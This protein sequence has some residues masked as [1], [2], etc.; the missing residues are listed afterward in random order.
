MKHTKKNTNVEC[1]QC[2]IWQIAVNVNDVSGYNV[3]NFFLFREIWDHA[4]D[5]WQHLSRS[6]FR[7][8]KRFDIGILG[9]ILKSRAQR[10]SKIKSRWVDRS[11]K[12]SL[13][14]CWDFKSLKT[15][16][17]LHV[18]K[19]MLRDVY[20]FTSQYLRASSSIS[21][22]PLLLSGDFIVLT[23]SLKWWLHRW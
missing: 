17:K 8:S 18:C 22:L 20:R 13:R 2:H 1:I 5:F 6:I 3:Q 15:K 10:L 12:H 4:V 21:L 7:L 16:K 9:E 11:H 23:S 19:L 14:N